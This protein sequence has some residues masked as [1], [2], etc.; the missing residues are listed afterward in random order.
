MRDYL[1]LT[2]YPHD[3]APNWTS[4]HLRREEAEG[5]AKEK[6]QGR[7]GYEGYVVATPYIT[8]EAHD[9]LVREALEEAADAMDA[10]PE[11][12]DPLRLKSQWL[13]NRAQQLKEDK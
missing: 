8:L 11:F 13:R 6:T 12:R 9:R 5:F 3:W 2:E 1:V 7:R 4:S 10:D